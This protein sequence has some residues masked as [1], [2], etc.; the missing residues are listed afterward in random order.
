MR[1]WINSPASPRRGRPP[2]A[3]SGP[4]NEA[5]TAPL[6]DEEV[7]PSGSLAVQQL[8]AG[9]RQL[10]AALPAGRELLKG[11][12]DLLRQE[13]SRPQP[14]K[15]ILHKAVAIIREKVIEQ[16]EIELSNA[17]WALL[18][19]LDDLIDHLPDEQAAST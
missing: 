1:T 8:F 11:E 15:S 7:A 5:A 17:G 3:S 14:E 2:K 9:L 10:Q 19:R 18:T 16:G 4:K 13:L 12:L 6:P